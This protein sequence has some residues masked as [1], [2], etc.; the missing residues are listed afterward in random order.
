MFGKAAVN[1]L[2]IRGRLAL[3]MLAVALPLNLVI[4]WVIW[5]LVHRADDS[6]RISL[7]YTARSIA[8]GVDAEIGKYMALAQSLARSPELLDDNI[9]AFEVEVRREFPAEGDAWALV[10]DVSGQQLMNTLVS[11]GQPLL[12]RN[13]IALEAQ[14][15]AL[16]TRSIVISGI[17]RGT[18]PE[19]HGSSVLPTSSYSR[20][21][22]PDALPGSIASW[23]TPAP[24]CPRSPSRPGRS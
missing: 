5:D 17:M 7:L 21:V 12:Q 4:V 23:V 9:H 24:L 15:R 14:H 19:K 18:A 11:P 16:A 13:P 8:A 2:S 20:A 1:R 10:A 6:Q 3:M 22:A